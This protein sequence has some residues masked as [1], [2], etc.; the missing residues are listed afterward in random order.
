MT[1][2]VLCR[3]QDLGAECFYPCAEADEVDGLEATVDP[4][5]ENI[6]SPCQ[7]ALQGL[8]QDS[9]Q[10]QQQTSMFLYTLACLDQR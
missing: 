6:I 3:L 10:E 1:A 7:Q 9:K 5:V 2:P 4:W 8:K